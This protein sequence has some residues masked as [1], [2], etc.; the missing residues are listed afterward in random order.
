VY[1]AVR[2]GQEHLG[3]AALKLSLLPWNARFTREAQLLA[4][5]SH[6]GIPRL[7]D[8]G[9]LLHPTGAEFAFLV[10]EW[11]EGMPLYAWAEQHSPTGQQVCRVLAGLARTLEALHASGAVHRDVKGDNVLVQLSDRLPV[12][13]DFGS[14]HFQ[15]APRLT[16]Q[17]LAPFTP[18]YL[19]PQACLFDI[20]LARNRNSYYPPSAADDLYAL[21][22]TAYRLVMG[23]YPPAMD[24]RQDEEGSWHV[25]SPDP[26]PLLERN[27][28]VA[29]PLR[30]VV[31]QLLSEVPEAR[32]TAAQVAQALEAMA[33]ERVPQRP[34]QPLPVAEVPPPNVQAPASESERPRPVRPSSRAWAWAPWV[35][36]AALGV[37][38]LLLWNVPSAPVPPGRVSSGPLA[39]L[40][41]HAPDAG[42]AA[43][44]EATPPKHQA[45]AK[46]PAEKKPVA[47]QPLPE[48]RP[49]Q[50]RPDQKGRCPGPRQVSING[51]CWLHY[52]SMP[53][54]ECVENGGVLFKDKCYTPAHA[55]P[56]KAQPTSTPTEAR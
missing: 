26:R 21:G 44:G 31:L 56:K 17:S 34:A 16:W 50:A 30:E 6:P 12:L 27:P 35:A 43:V 54:E 8:Q 41:S 5:L 10:M 9:A 42:T 25:S 47:Q 33:D 29:P 23:Q 14:G 2:V 19:S 18:E 39:P 7:L 22:V 4:R 1:R 55:P 13:L 40:A 37:C 11:V 53:T 36:L 24:A 38:A 45:P 32:G 48:P 15:G 49:G 52:S 51:G 20:R 3:P 46:P 28:R